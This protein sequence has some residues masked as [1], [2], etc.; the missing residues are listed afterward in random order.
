VATYSAD[1]SKQLMAAVERFASSGH[2]CDDD[3]DQDDDEVE[4]VAA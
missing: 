2:D 3:Q 1:Y 4:A